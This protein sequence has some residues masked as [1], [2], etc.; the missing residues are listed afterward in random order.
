MAQRALHLVETSRLADDV[1]M[2]TVFAAAAC[3]C[4]AWRG[5]RGRIGVSCRAAAHGTSESTFRAVAGCHRAAPA[6]SSADDLGRPDVRR[7]QLSEAL[8]SIAGKAGESELRQQLL[9]V[10]Q[11]V[12]GVP[13]T[14]TASLRE[15]TPGELR[16]L[17]LLPTHLSFREIG[18]SLFLSRNT[19]KTQAIAGY[20]KLG[21]QSRAQAVAT[22]APRVAPGF[23]PRR[24]TDPGVPCATKP[25]GHGGRR[26]TRPDCKP[27]L[28]SGR[29]TEGPPPRC[30]RA[31]SGADV[32]H[33]ARIEK[34]GTQSSNAVAQG[35]GRG[36]MP[37]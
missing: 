4:V 2:M 30:L 24:R 8:D 32:R 21:V 11:L 18:E 5:A 25:P 9:R 37:P 12:D 15:L 14:R 20:R 22:A 6:G 33:C 36:K 1:S 26:V 3:L 16:V 27:P 10:A 28:L 34:G 17:Q 35:D 31:R 23:R 29:P 19:V 13:S 7:S